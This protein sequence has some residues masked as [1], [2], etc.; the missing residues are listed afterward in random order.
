MVHG[1]DGALRRVGL[2]LAIQPGRLLGAADL[3]A[4]AVQ[5][6][7]L[8]PADVEPVVAGRPGLAVL[9]VG[10]VALRAGGVVLVVADRGPRLPEQRA[11]GLVVGAHQLRQRRLGV[12]R[13]PEREHQRRVERL[14]PAPR[15]PPAGRTPP[16]PAPRE[17]RRCHRRQPPAHR[18]AVPPGWRSARPGRPSPSTLRPSSRRRTR[19]PGRRRRAQRQEQQDARALRVGARARPY[20]EGRTIRPGRART[21]RAGSGCGTRSSGPAGR[22]RGPRSR[23]CSSC[24]RARG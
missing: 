23:R 14:A 10:V 12:L 21:R 22:T 24:V 16:S 13:V 17:R 20:A 4:V 11:P 1:H 8:P 3:G 5:D 6:G 7:D 2:H 19:R 15:S 9:E 18:P